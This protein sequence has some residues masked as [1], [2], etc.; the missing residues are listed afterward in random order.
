M[1]AGQLKPHF[2]KG[3]IILLI[4]GGIG[5]AAINTGSNIQWFIF[6]IILSVVL[7]SKI[8]G[9]INLIG[10]RV[11]IKEVPEVF[12]NRKSYIPIAICNKKRIGSANNIWLYLSAES[13]DEFEKVFFDKIKR[14]EDKVF[15][16]EANFPKRGECEIKAVELLSGFPIDFFRNCRRI[17]VNQKV[18][19]YPEIISLAPF[20]RRMRIFSE[21]N[22]SL[23]KGEG[24][25]EILNIYRYSGSESYKNIHWKIT[26]KKDE[27]WA[28]EFSR[29]ESKKLII[30]MDWQEI[31]FNLRERAISLAA[32]LTLAL[33]NNLLIWRLISGNFDTGFGR[34]RTHLIKCLKYLALIKEYP[35]ASFYSENGPLIKI[36]DL[37][38]EYK[39]AYE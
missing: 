36:S 25:N 35:F 32:S 15:F 6:S 38:R 4:A 26:A 13:Q 33:N 20:N 8:V 39:T 1:V 34:G 9:V 30:V 7:I 14:K 2:H 37:I 19:V 24:G 11:K 16:Y 27:L 28:K 10:V 29:E 31:D 22:S 18:L 3:I 21:G 17:E 5:F 23:M 12:A